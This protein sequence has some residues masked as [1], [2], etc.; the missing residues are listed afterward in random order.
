MTMS[1]ATAAASIVGG[2]LLAVVGIVGVLVLIVTTLADVYTSGL[3]L[4]LGLP[5]LFVAGGT[6][7][8]YGVALL[9]RE[10]TDVASDVSGL[11]DVESSG[12]VT[13]LRRLYDKID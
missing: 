4:W 3:A 13:E 5:L 2:L 6:L 7:T 1:K 8:V 11:S 9:L 12:D 10:V